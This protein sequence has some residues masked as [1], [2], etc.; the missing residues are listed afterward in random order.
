MKK[1]LENIYNV[2]STDWNFIRRDKPLLVIFIFA[3]IAY[4]LVYSLIYSPEIYTDV[5]IAIVDED[6]SAESRRMARSLDASPYIELSASA[7]SLEEAKDMFMRR[8]VSGVILI[9]KNFERD[10]LRGVKTNFAV[11]T[12]ASYF[13]AFKQTFF[14]A[15]DA[16][17]SENNRIE[18]QRFQMVGKSDVEAQFLSE[19]VRLKSQTLFNRY[20]GYASFIMPCVLI[21]IIQQTLLIGIG[22]LSGVWEERK[23]YPTKYRAKSGDG[24]Y[25]PIEIIFG[26]ML[27]Y[28]GF[29]LVLFTY[30]IFIEYKLFN[31]PSRASS[32]ELFIFILP[33]L[34][35]SVALAITLS[36][37]FKFRETSLITYFATS[38]PL[39]MLTGISWSETALPTSLVWLGGLFPS[40]PAVAGFVRMQ[41]MGASF[42]DVGCEYIHLWVLSV[43]FCATAILSVRLILRRN[44][45]LEKKF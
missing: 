28:V 6:N 24:A 42:S 34:I 17:L 20:A 13:L 12:D 8:E 9:P 26:K 7:S 35:S 40:T 38:L 30:I 3:L 29:E 36:P 32:V 25:R 18:L 45:L 1:F 11:Y 43:V 31:F 4:S 33:Y 37:L 44:N 10:I 39:I 41:S 23:L 14:G 15:I 16:M 22:M 21:L 19:P 2:A 27:L 5:K